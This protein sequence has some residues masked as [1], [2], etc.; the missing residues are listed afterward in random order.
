MNQALIKE[1]I[2]IETGRPSNTDSDSIIDE[3]MEEHSNLKN[4]IIS[5]TSTKPK[6]LADLKSVNMNS[7]NKPILEIKERPSRI[8]KKLTQKEKLELDLNTKA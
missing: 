8:H 6:K 2:M 4:S 5:P 1:K 3:I 7:I